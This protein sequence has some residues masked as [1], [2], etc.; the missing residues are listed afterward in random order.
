MAAFEE[1]E[2]SLNKNNQDHQLEDCIT[3]EEYPDHITSYWTLLEQGLEETINFNVSPETPPWLDLEKFK[4]GQ[5]FARDHYF[6]IQYSVL[7]ALCLLYSEPFF[8][9]GFMMTGKSNT[10]FKAFKKFLTTASI[11]T[12]WY[13]EDVW[14][15][16]PN[17]SKMKLNRAQRLHKYVEQKFKAYSE[18]ELNEKTSIGDVDELSARLPLHMIIKE[19]YKNHCK[20]SI[21]YKKRSEMKVDVMI[22]QAG[23]AGGQLG[24]MGLAVTYPK[25]FGLYFVTEEDLDSFVHFWRGIGYL[26]GVGDEYNFGNVNLDEVRYRTKATID[27]LFKPAMREVHI[28]WEYMIRCM[29]DGIQLC[30]PLPIYCFESLVLDVSNMLGVPVPGLRKWMNFQ[31]YLS[32]YAVRFAI[33]LQVVPCIAAMSNWWLRWVMKKAGEVSPKVLAQ[34]KAKKYSYVIYEE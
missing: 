30:M 10:P 15:N 33:M 2:K 16:E 6:S 5:K 12:A 28:N 26:L 24:V 1:N 8:I 18:E 14:S 22:S 25:H 23:I 11:F 32:F 21:M 29:L 31:Q 4:R 17:S 19:D 7:T 27:V 13:D 9:R 20:N 3:L 34:W